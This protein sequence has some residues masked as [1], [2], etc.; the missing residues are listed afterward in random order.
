ME[1]RL[2]PPLQSCLPRLCANSSFPTRDMTHP[3]RVGVGS[4]GC[5]LSGFCF[6]VF[7]A[8]L[9]GM[10][11]LSS[12]TREEPAPPEM[13]VQSLSHWT[14][15]EVPGCKLESPVESINLL[16][17]RPLLRPIK[18]EPLGARSRRWYLE[19]L[20]QVIP[21]HRRAWELLLQ[22]G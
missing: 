8:A 5:K 14:A 7:L 11:D 16:R 22:G 3:S 18:P 4:S 2:S 12:L 10:W 9:H 1:H 17:P 6:C 13:E 20:F 21:L 15:R 19:K